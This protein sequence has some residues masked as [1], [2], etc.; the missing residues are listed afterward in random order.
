MNVWTF[1]RLGVWVSADALGLGVQRGSHRR[2]SS[3]D[4]ATCATPDP[5]S[6]QPYVSMGSAVFFPSPNEPPSSRADPAVHATDQATTLDQAQAPTGNPSLAYQTSIDTDDSSQSA[7]EPYS[8]THARKKLPFSQPSRPE[9]PVLETASLP[10]QEEASDTFA[11]LGN[12][13]HLLPDPDVSGRGSVA[14]SRSSIQ[15]LNSR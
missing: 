8:R 3:M 1:G 7:P 2:T 9:P 13:H 15:D 14:S 6:G 4:S 11:D 12:R 10:D 5:P